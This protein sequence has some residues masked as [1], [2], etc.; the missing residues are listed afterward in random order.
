MPLLYTFYG[1]DFTGSTDVLEQ[2]ALHGVPAL[3]FFAPPSQEQL[4]SFGPV[5]AF[6]VAGESRSRPPEWMDE[7][8]PA[9]LHSLAASGARV[10]HYKVCSTF[11]S[12]P[13]QGSIGRAMELGLAAVGSRFA[14]IV[15]GAPHLRR[16]VWEGRLFAAAPSGVIQRIDRHPMSRHPVTPMREADLRRHLA[17]QTGMPI[18]LVSH[19]DLDGAEHASAA[20]EREVAGGAAAVLFD[21]VDVASLDVTGRILWREAERRQLFGVGS[22]GLTAALIHAWRRA[23]LLPERPTETAV[24]REAP[25]LVLSGSCSPMTARQIEWALRNGFAGRRLDPGTLCGAAPR[26]AALEQVV[27]DAVSSL[28]AGKSVVLYTALG[29]ATSRV[30]GEALGCALGRLLREILERVRVRRVVLCGGDT[31][32]HAVQQLGLSALS[33]LASLQTGAPL[34][35]AHFAA[36]EHRPLELV[37][38]GGQVGTEDFFAVARGDM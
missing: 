38:K 25:L 27:S 10:V 13:G 31:S 23:G 12:S 20:L 11:D 36:A 6:G 37:L 35:R 22:S 21:T 9:I 16:F 5:L 28:G 1:D 8:L 2:L 33:W 17:A 26:D 3:L 32:S 29:G 4:R 14:P 19:D 34:C 15:V 7:H 24:T 30:A 18:G